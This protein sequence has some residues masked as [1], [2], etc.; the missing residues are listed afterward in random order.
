MEGWSMNWVS[1]FTETIGPALVQVG[2]GG[3]G[4]FTDFIGF[5][6][7]S[8][9]FDGLLPGEKLQVTIDLQGVMTLLHDSTTPGPSGGYYLLA[10]PNDDSRL[11]TN[12]RVLGITIDHNGPTGNR[13]FRDINDPVGLPLMGSGSSWSPDPADLTDIPSTGTIGIMQGT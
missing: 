12:V 2:I 4:K 1:A 10:A 3:D 8:P 9:L 5:G 13:A 7:S 6:Q 11:I